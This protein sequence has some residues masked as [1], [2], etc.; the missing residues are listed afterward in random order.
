MGMKRYSYRKASTGSRLAARHAGK[1]FYLTN[2]TARGLKPRQVRNWDNDLWMFPYYTDRK[3]VPYDA[4]P[5][6]PAA[7]AD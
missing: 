3:M 7:K 4:R 5:G 2:I 6:G 1:R